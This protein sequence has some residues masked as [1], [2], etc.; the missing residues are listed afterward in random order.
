MKTVVDGKTVRED[1]L[2]QISILIHHPNKLELKK[3]VP[4]RAAVTIQKVC[5]SRRAARFLRELLSVGASTLKV[6]AHCV[7]RAARQ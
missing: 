6:K 3:K 4:P 2:S 7:V 5:H 1:L